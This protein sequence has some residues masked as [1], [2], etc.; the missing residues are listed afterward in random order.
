[1]TSDYEHISPKL[2]WRERPKIRIERIQLPFPE[3]C[4]IHTILHLQKA[5]CEDF[6][7]TLQLPPLLET[8]PS[9]RRN[10][11]VELSKP[12]RLPS[13]FPEK[14]LCDL[15]KWPFAKRPVQE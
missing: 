11:H 3:T 15:A 8:D 9:Y 10:P 7:A 2:L 13:R 4:N 6:P 5:S 12:R 14:P 1:M